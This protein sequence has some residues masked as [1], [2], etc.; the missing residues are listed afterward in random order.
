MADALVVGMQDITSNEL[1]AVTGGVVADNS[2]SPIG[3]RIGDAL[4]LPRD[5]SGDNV[6]GRLGG[7]V[8]QLWQSW[9][10]P[11]VLR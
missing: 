10:H 2:G 4:R 8:R 1:A 11:Y 3:N 7:T 9:R 6:I 5:S